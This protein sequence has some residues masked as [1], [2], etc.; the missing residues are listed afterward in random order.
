M[1]QQLPASPLGEERRR[2]A[3]SHE[4]RWVGDLRAEP[5]DVSQQERFERARSTQRRWIATRPEFTDNEV[6]AQQGTWNAILRVF[7]AGWGALALA[8]SFAKGTLI[9][10][11]HAR[12]E[13]MRPIRL[14]ERV[15]LFVIAVAVLGFA[16]WWPT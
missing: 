1:G 6:L 14:A 5:I 16:V 10:A 2:R 15:G 4:R 11:P 12:T 3:Y 13:W 7:V 9:G 8:G